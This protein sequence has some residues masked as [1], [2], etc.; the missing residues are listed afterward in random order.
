VVDLVAHQVLSLAPVRLLER[1]ETTYVKRL[2]EM[3]RVRRHTESDNLVL[4]AVLLEFER[5]VALVAINN[6]QT[7]ASYSPPLC[8]RIKVL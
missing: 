4:L 3:R 6:K 2:Q 7:I 5:V 8:V 1:R